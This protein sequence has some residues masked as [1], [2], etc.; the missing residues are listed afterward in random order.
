MYVQ[1]YCTVQFSGGSE[2]IAHREGSGFSDIKMQVRF[3]QS[4]HWSHR[5]GSLQLS[6]AGKGQQPATICWIKNRLSYKIENN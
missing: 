2:N 5:W 6:Q 1:L 3:G 4:V